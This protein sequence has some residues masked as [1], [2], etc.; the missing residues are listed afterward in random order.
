[1][2]LKDISGLPPEREIEFSIDLI[3]GAGSITIAPYRMSLVELVEIK[4]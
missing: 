1:M 3:P 4:K 2:F